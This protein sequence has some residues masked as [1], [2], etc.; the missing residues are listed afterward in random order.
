MKMYHFIRTVEKSSGWQQFTACGNTLGEAKA[1]Y[2][3]GEYEFDCEEVEVTS[4]G[5]PEWCLEEQGVEVDCDDVE[6]N[7][8]YALYP[9]D[10]EDRD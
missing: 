9:R 4:L 6:N 7:N 8:R 10:L 1:A 3:R 5:E 2:E